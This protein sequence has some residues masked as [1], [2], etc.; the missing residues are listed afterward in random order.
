MQARLHTA[1]ADAAEAEL[2]HV[3][4]TEALKA[5]RRPAPAPRAVPEARPEESQPPTRAAEL[6]EVRQRDRAQDPARLAEEVSRIVT[7]VRN[8]R[9]LFDRQHPYDGYAACVY[10]QAKLDGLTSDRA[11]ERAGEALLA[12]MSEGSAFTPAEVQAYERRYK[13]LNRDLRRA[14]DARTSATLLASVHRITGS[15]N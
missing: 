4:S 3:H 10:L 5:A 9:P 11:T 1:R 13:A 12:E 14:A 15:A 6:R 8:A 7:R 2:R